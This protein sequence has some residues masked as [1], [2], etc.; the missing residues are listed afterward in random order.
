MFDVIIAGC[1]PTGAMLAAEVRLHNVRVLV[2]D[3]ETE[4]AYLV[5]IPQPV[6]AALLEEHAIERGAQVRPA[7][8]PRPATG[9]HRT[10]ERR[11]RRLDR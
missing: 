4:H 9:P 10:P 6:I 8:R 7:S 2:L 3:K 1:G 5:G 11:P